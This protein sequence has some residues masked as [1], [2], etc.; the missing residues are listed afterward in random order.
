MTSVG[1][2]LTRFFTR[3][4]SRS[5]APPRE[6]RPKHAEASLARQRWVVWSPMPTAETN[7]KG[8]RNVQA[9]RCRR[10]VRRML[11]C[12][13]PNVRIPRR[14][15][16]FFTC[17]RDLKPW[18]FMRNRAILTSRNRLICDL[19]EILLRRSARL[20]FTRHPKVEPLLPSQR[21]A[22][23]KAL[24]RTHYQYYWSDNPDMQSAFLTTRPVRRGTV[25]VPFRRGLIVQPSTV[26]NRNVQ[27]QNG[28]PVRKQPSGPVPSG[29]PNGDE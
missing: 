25:I 29:V 7:A 15:P 20:R 1:K 6:Q 14:S 21:D 12:V 3:P 8:R 27:P 26:H 11:D 19:Q 4:A 23:P 5:K 22:M 16:A 28:N 24:M 18:S 9:C 13:V 17:Q 2:I 10:L